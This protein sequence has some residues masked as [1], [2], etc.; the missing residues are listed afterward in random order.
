MLDPT[1][2]GERGGGGKN[3]GGKKKKKLQTSISPLFSSFLCY[4]CIPGRKEPVESTI[5][6]PMLSSGLECSRRLYDEE[7]SE[8]VLLL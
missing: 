8:R 5:R 6:E 2:A 3:V 7:D 1:A 4:G